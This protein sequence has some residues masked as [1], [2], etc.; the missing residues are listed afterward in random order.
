MLD[1][2]PDMDDIPTNELPSLAVVDDHAGLPSQANSEFLARVGHELRGS[3]NAILGFGQLLEMRDLDER[4]RADV[5]QI[6]TAGRHM[7]DLIASVLE[8]WSLDAGGDDAAFEPVDICAL[9]RDA[10]ELTAP[11]R[12]ERELELSLELPPGAVHCLAD[13]R[14]TSKALLNVLSN[15]MKYNR[16][17]GSVTIAVADQGDAVDVRVTDTGV[18]IAAELMPRLFDPFDRLGAEHTDIEGIGL[19]LAVSKRYLERMRGR[20]GVT[21]VPGSGTTVTLRLPTA[22]AAAVPATVAAPPR[23]TATRTVLSI[24]DKR[25]NAALLEHLLAGR[26]EVRLLTARD[27]RTGLDTA[28]SERP[29]LVLLDLNLRDMH[30][31]DVL[32]VLRAGEQTSGV[33]VVVLSADATPCRAEELMRAGAQECL[34]RPVDVGEL[35]RVLDG[36]LQALER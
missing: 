35:L 12:E 27:G 5:E 18:G 33:P 24:E 23:C 17:H 9:V 26:P 14:R 13:P 22:H 25:T 6:L 31:I 32:R 2:K 1:D 4:E 10:V 15:A 16:H 19:G 8:I 3:L 28:R 36:A 20:I 30:G 29:D 21:S 7:L 11:L 34:T